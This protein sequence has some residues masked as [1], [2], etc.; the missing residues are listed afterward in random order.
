MFQHEVIFTYTQN[1]NMEVK[2]YPKADQRPL[3]GICGK[4]RMSYRFCYF[5]SVLE[6]TKWD[7]KRFSK[8]TLVFGCY[9]ESDSM[10]RRLCLKLLFLDTCNLKQFLTMMSQT[11]G[12]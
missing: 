1:D 8:Q 7:W 3:N 5:S 2:V 4:S 10:S 6:Q 12:M 11:S 9:E